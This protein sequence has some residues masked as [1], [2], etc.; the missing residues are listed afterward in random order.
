M[1]ADVLPLSSWGI[2]ARLY[3]TYRYC[4]P[5]S[6]SNGKSDVAAQFDLNSDG[7]GPLFATCSR[8]LVTLT[9]EIGGQRES[10]YDGG[11]AMVQE[12]DQTSDPWSDPC[13]LRAARRLC[14]FHRP[15][16]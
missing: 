14:F 6:N 2:S 4:R 12:F 11:K 5:F 16:A 7:R 3:R 15:G 9:T 10:K 1:S 13:S 8:A